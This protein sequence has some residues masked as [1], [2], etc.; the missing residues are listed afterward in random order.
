MGPDTRQ[1]LYEIYCELDELVTEL[2]QIMRREGGIEYERAKAYWL[3]SLSSGLSNSE[4]CTMNPTFNSFLKDA[5]IVN[6]DG[7]FLD[8]AGGASCLEEDEHEI[9]EIY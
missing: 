2:T 6:D 7:V 9:D 1:R 3:A 5:G 8:L 4:Y